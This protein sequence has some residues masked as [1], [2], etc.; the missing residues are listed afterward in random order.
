MAQASTPVTSSR[1][2][3]IALSNV[4]RFSAIDEM[5]QSIEN[6]RTQFYDGDNSVQYIG[7]THIVPS[8]FENFDRMRE[9]ERI[10]RSNKCTYFG[11]ESTLIVKIH[12]RHIT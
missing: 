7:I 5:I 8:D 11:E 10:L 12:G 6:K 4:A 1:S 9:E 3:P 2:Y